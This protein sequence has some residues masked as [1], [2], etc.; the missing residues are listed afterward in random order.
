MTSISTSSASDARTWCFAL[1]NRALL[2]FV[3]ALIFL[4]SAL[5]ATSL[6]PIPALILLAGCIGSLAL[7]AQR[8]QTMDGSALDASID[9]KR[10][11]LC[12]GLAC[13]ILVF[14]G[15]LHLFFA[16]LDWRTRDAV[17]ADLTQ[18]EFPI[19]YNV[20]GADYIL[21]A[22]LGMYMFPASVGHV[23]GLLG[24]H[25]ALLAQNALVLGSI[26]YLLMSLGLGWP[27]LAILIFFSGLSIV[28]ASLGFA[29]TREIKIERLVVF[30]LDAWHPWFQYSS[31]MVQ[32]FWV[33]N[34]ALPGWWLATLLLLQT[35]SETDSA[36][37]GVSLAGAIFWSP[38]V[39]I[40]VA[41]WLLYLAATDWRRHLL[42][43]RTWIGVV[44]GACF[45]PVALYMVTGSSEIS[46]GLSFDK[47]EFFPS[48]IIFIAIQLPAVRFIYLNRG[49]VP[50]HMLVL[51]YFAAASLLILPFFSFGPSNDLVM[52]GST[53]PLVIVAFV[54][55]GIVCHPA[56]S[57]QTRL[58]GYALIILST[59]SALLEI[60]RNVAYP[61]YNIS[62]CTLMD[63]R[64]AMG[65]KEIP[66]NY[67]VESSDI[68]S[69]LMETKVPAPLNARSRRCWTDLD[70][71]HE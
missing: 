25:I 44:V 4:P 43:P 69:W 51:F 40:P 60:A 65:A 11:S 48:Y 55:G 61:R 70:N 10:L 3:S 19:G 24:A 33:P 34:H 1:P 35:R 68:P 64:H 42:A 16:P 22:P 53:A 36:T 8:P 5:F 52:R 29:I 23:F 58:I 18:G 13:I 56:I 66:T 21:R 27:H 31:S 14:G 41:F 46:H 38:L 59:P 12:I 57:R 15:E 30:G 28:G 63:A 67:I 2:I 26:F 32:F 47:L 17:L 6:R 37:L 49:L 54:F 20:A 39:V 9:I 7:I 62:D 71:R 50:R 45:L